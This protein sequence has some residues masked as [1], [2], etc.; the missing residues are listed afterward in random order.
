M[1]NLPSAN[2]TQ[3]IQGAAALH[4]LDVKAT[5]T[6]YRDVLGLT[7][8]VST[9]YWSD[10]MLGSVRL[11]LHPPFKDGTPQK[12]SGGWILGVE[13]KDLAA[14]KIRLQ[15]SGNPTSS[16]YHEVPGGVVLDFADPDGNP[17]Q[18]IQL[19]AQMS[20]FS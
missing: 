2:P 7:P 12:A 4:V 6:F 3:F 10:F 19:G 15:D 1:P 8:V 18:A 14:L 20:D 13:T 9:P 16:K 17:L 5:A 11:G